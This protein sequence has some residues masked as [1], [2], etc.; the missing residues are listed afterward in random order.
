[1]TEFTERTIEVNG[2][3]LTLL[4]GGK[5]EPLL[6]LHEELGHPGWLSWHRKLAQ[7]YKLIV[8]VQPGFHSERIHWMTS[9]RDLACFY[10]FML[11]D[12]GLQGTRVIGFSFGGWVAAE[13]AV[14]NPAQFSRMVLVAPFGIKPS[15][16]Y[17]MDMFPIASAT[18]LRASVADPESTPEFSGLY[19]EPSAKQFE[20][21]ED[22][23]TEC[24]RLGWEP[25]MHNPALAP[26]L[27]GVRGLPALIVWGDRDAILPEAAVRAYQKA[28]PDSR[29]VVLKGAGHRPE[30]ERADDFIRTVED[31]LN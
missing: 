9:V 29:L 10:G 13:M 31:F 14:N 7:R 6:V 17:I 21:W 1:M 25:Y 12:Q 27:P 3:P 18:Y 2:S 26:M 15:E 28:I 8:P 11:R 22:A 30:I 5:G 24:A 23:R 19:G 4:E 16:G 20:D